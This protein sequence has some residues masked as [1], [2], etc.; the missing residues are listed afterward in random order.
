MIDHY[1]EAG[2]LMEIDG[3][4]PLDVVTAALLEAIR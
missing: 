4:R 3:E 2:V 1:R